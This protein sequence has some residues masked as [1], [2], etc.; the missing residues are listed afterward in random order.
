MADELERFGFVARGDQRELRVAFERPHDIADL[1]IDLRGQ[2]GLGE[3]RPDRRRDLAAAD[4]AGKSEA[5][6]VGQGDDDRRRPHGMPCCFGGGGLILHHSA[7]VLG[8]RSRFVPRSTYRQPLGYCG[9][10]EVT[11]SLGLRRC[12]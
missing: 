12:E 3:P 4:R 10:L 6:A 1:A 8:G 2:R 9:D 7:L 5:F 11:V